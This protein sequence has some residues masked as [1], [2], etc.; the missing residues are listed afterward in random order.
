M[1]NYSNCPVC[2]GTSFTHFLECTDY[3]VSNENFKIVSC[4]NCSFKF[5][6][7]IPDLTKLG[8]YYKSE[9]YV[10]HSNTTKGIINKAYHLVRN[11]TLL[12]KLRLVNHYVSRGTI[13]DYGCGTGA[14][15]NLCQ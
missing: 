15:L 12:R 9:D 4:S 3:T 13:L 5:T 14:F 1:F 2:H 10:S 7:P 11:L 6:N 8:D